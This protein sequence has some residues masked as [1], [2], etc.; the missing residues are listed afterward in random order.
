MINHQEIVIFSAL[1][2]FLIGLIVAE[3]YARKA[4]RSANRV[5]PTAIIKNSQHIVWQ[6]LFYYGV[7]LTFALLTWL[8]VHV[9]EACY[10]LDVFAIAGGD[11]QKLANR[12]FRFK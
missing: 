12:F 11:V 9:P 4:Y 1:I 8:G 10:Y 6:K 7:F 3:V 2:A 5:V